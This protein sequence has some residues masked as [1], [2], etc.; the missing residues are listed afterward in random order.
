MKGHVVNLFRLLPLLIDSRDKIK[1]MNWTFRK[2]RFL[3]GTMA[4]G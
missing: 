2:Q 3:D 4:M 1:N